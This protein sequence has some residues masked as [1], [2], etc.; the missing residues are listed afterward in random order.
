M[1]L[2]GF[3]KGSFQCLVTTDVAARGLDIPEV[4]LVVQCEPP[5]DIHAYIH[6]SG[7]TGRAGREGVCIIFYKSSQEM[8]LRRIEQ[9]GELVGVSIGAGLMF[10]PSYFIVTLVQ[11]FSTFLGCGPLLLTVIQN[12]ESCG[13]PDILCG[14]LIGP[15]TPGW[16]QLH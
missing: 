10:T 4:D 5:K 6:R 2:E 1:T 8:Q 13:P 15:W 14:P 9:V 3:R 12:F 7:R 16:E 11:R